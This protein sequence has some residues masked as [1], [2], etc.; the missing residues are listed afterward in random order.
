VNGYSTLRGDAF[1]A[2]A[3]TVHRVNGYS[4][5]RGDAFDAG[6]SRWAAIDWIPV[7]GDE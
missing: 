2:V 4:T 7:I 1:D 6:S 5:L 3:R